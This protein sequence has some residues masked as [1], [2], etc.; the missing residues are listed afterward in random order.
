MM[1]TTVVRRSRV[2]LPQGMSATDEVT[3]IE[4]LAP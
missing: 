3:P 4:L 1:A 2:R